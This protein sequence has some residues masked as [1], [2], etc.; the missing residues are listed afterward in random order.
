MIGTDPAQGS[1]T[2]VVPTVVVP[3]RM[4]FPRDGSVL[5]VPG[6]GQELASS[7]LFTAFPSVVG[8]TQYA[9]VYRRAD[10]WD[11]VSTTSPDYHTLVGAPTILPTQTLTVPAA[12]GHT[13]L[14]SP[15]NRLFGYVDGEGFSGQLKQLIRSLQIDPRTLAIFLEPNT[16]PTFAGTSPDACPGPTCLVAGG[17]HGALITGTRA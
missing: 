12:L 5:D 8:T 6:M 1:A 15:A 2:T 10:F 13:A 9:D 7:P 3:L 14:F 11:Q 4:V 17:Y 16:E